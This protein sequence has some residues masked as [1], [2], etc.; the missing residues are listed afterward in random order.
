MA[1]YVLGKYETSEQLEKR[2]QQ[3]DETGAAADTSE[4]NPQN[5]RDSTKQVASVFPEFES[6]ES[7]DSQNEAGYMQWPTEALR[8]IY[9]KESAAT[10]TEEQ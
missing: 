2:L 5:I 6:E 7:D 9:A 8:V 10:A 1:E 4:I 3:Q